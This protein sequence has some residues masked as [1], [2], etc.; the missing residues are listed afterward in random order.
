MLRLLWTFTHQSSTLF[1][2]VPSFFIAL[3]ASET[4]TRTGTLRYTHAHRPRGGATEEKMA[5]VSFLRKV[6]R[7]CMAVIGAH[8]FMT[9]SITVFS[10][11]STD[12]FFDEHWRYSTPVLMRRRNYTCP[13]RS[14]FFLPSL[15]RDERECLEAW[16]SLQ[17][18]QTP[19]LMAPSWSPHVLV[20]DSLAILDGIS[21]VRDAVYGL[22]FCVHKVTPEVVE[23]RRERQDS[24]T[25]VHCKT[26]LDVA[27]RVPFTSFTFSAFRLPAFVTL[28]LEAP[29][30][31]PGKLRIAAADHRWWGGRIWSTQTGS[32]KPP[33]GDVGDLV[34]R[35]NGFA[36][37]IMIT[38]GSTVHE[39]VAYAR[40]RA[41]TVD[42]R[43]Q[44]LQEEQVAMI[45]QDHAASIEGAST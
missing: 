27:V 31:R 15:T 28:Q 13:W 18:L 26:V 5:H 4:P 33:W 39:R 9:G 23:V 1:P 24:V 14:D 45:Q 16:L 10:R 44:R 8:A 38:K 17:S 40:A 37:S 21:E 30:N 22:S 29:S 36:A 2:P 25:F 12:R 41:R 3:V 6:G 20:Q 43:V 35:Y 42:R 32:V 19:P 7:L 11:C 34:R